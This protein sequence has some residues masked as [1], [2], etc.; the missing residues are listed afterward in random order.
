M[1]TI[2]KVVIMAGGTGGHVFPGLA[3]AKALQEKNVTVSWLGSV[4]GM[5]T[6]LVPQHGIAIHTI[7]IKG[8]RGKSLLEQLRFPFH[9]LHAIIQAKHYFKQTK[10]DLVLGMGGFVA[11]PGAI[12][13]K[14]SRIPLI[15]HE[16]NSIAG[17]TNR[18]LAKIAN[19]VLCAFPSTFPA[20]V[21]AIVV[22][23]PVR[24]EIENLNY[25]NHQDKLHL[26][27]F[28]GSRG[29]QIFNDIIPQAIALLPENIRP[30]VCH[31]SGAGQQELTQ[32]N[33]AKHQVAAEVIA[34]IDDMAKRYATADI[35]ICRAGA[36]TLAEITAVGLPAILIPYPHA[37]DDH[38]TANAQYLVKNGAAILLPQS[39]LSAKTLNEILKDLLINHNK[40]FA[41]AEASRALRKTNVTKKIIE[42]CIYLEF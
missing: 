34:F 1:A 30:I 20:R 32:I 41:M 33:Y 17:M 5:E 31:Q 6:T 2:T 18:W 27:I 29:A 35:L 12:A 37:V 4:G 36:L 24:K 16:Q 10:P 42:E 7:A 38:Q 40:R 3:I 22:G 26:L 23:N 8:L 19:K 28:G 11:G 25:A 9:L 13:A 15:I 14:L 21:K 39:D